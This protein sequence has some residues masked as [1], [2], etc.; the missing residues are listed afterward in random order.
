DFL[1]VLSPGEDGSWSG[2]IDI[3]AQGV[4]AAPL[5]AV[6]VDATQATFELAVKPAARWEAS[7]RDDGTWACRFTQGSA[8][9]SCALERVDG[10]EDARAALAPPR[11]QTPQPPF[12]YAAHD[13]TFDNEGVTLAGTLTVPPGDGPFP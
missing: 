10:L 7:L 13:V 11:P 1:V 2:T 6:Q 12:P 5:S 4:S 9:L 8:T 3:P